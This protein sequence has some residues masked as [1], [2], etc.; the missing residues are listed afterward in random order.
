MQKMTHR[1][2]TE[3][4]RLAFE[5]HDH[6]VSCN[7]KFKEADT[8]HLGYSQNDKPLYVCD[9]C[10]AQLKETAVR[11]YFM[12]RPYEVPDPSSKLWRYMDF[13]KYAA[14]LSSGALYFARADCFEDTFEGAKG[15]RR[16]KARWDEHYLQFFREA[17]KNPPEGHECELSKSEI[18]EQA[19]KLLRDL[20]SGGELQRKRTFVSCWHESEHE[21][22]A[23]WRLY[24]SFI[25][26]AVAIRTSYQSLYTALGRNPSINIGRIEYIDMKRNYAGVNDAFWRKRKSFEHEREVRA[27]F[28][29]FECQKT[30]KLTPC[31]LNVLIEEVFVSPRAPSW[32]VA[33]VNDINDKYSIKVKVSPSELVEEPF[34]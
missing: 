24:S 18:E 14:L 3:L 9:H 21:S 4:R 19:Q 10:S 20:E 23:M 25:D 17:I 5:H 30:G 16:N 34:F 8:S 27:I 13:T 11:H 33:L 28:S 1:L 32:F 2:T 7:Y 6:C 15:L 22:E 31:D 29:D 26:N 12:P